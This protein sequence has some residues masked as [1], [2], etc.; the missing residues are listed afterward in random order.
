MRLLSATESI[1]PAIKR[2]KE[3]LFQPFQ[4]GRSWKLAAVAYL[5]AMGLVFMPY[6]LFLFAIPKLPNIAGTNIGLA[7]AAF[8]L[9]SSAVILVFFYLGSRFQFVLFAF[10]LERS[11]TIAPLW[12]R[13]GSRTWPW[14]GL[15]LIPSLVVTAIF[16]V[17]VW[18]S[19]HFLIAQ[20]SLQQPGQ[21]PSA[22]MFAALL[23]FYAFILG[24]VVLLMLCSSLLS[25][26]VLPPIALEDAPLAD[27]LGRFFQL[28]KA[29]PGQLLLFTLFKILLA[30]AGMMIMQIIVLLAELIL[31]IPFGLLALLGWFL[32]RSLGPAGHILL[33]AGAITLGLIFA[34]GMFYITVL[35]MGCVHIFY[36]AYALYFLGGRYPQLGN[37]LEPPPPP[38]AEP[39]PLLSPS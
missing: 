31:L 5:S 4:K 38:P 1:S 8:G 26:F 22:E 16:A 12:R 39:P 18:R 3:I 25:D 27:A 21:P 6:P 20:T 17:P 33:F 32:F 13:Y 23:S 7:L 9:I 30:I 35:V 37:L 10:T 14:L 29:E 28:I 34:A 24:P 11:T 19:I 36:Q 2:T 15:K